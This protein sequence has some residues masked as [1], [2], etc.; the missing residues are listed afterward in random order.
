MLVDE[1][2]LLWAPNVV[3]DGGI[4]DEEELTEVDNWE[5][6]GALTSVSIG[7]ESE[8]LLLLLMLNSF[9]TGDVE[10]GVGDDEENPPATGVF[11]TE[12][13]EVGIYDELEIG[14]VC[15]AIEEEICESP[16]EAFELEDEIP[17][18]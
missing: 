15:W 12:I 7:A 3:N 2:L 16:I 10:I 4:G 13:E 9:A 14:I 8:I 6:C 17:I 5:F 1:L 11:N 18:T